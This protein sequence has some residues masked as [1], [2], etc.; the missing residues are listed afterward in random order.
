MRFV[1]VMFDG[2]D[3]VGMTDNTHQ[4]PFIALASA[5]AL[6]HTPAG[7]KV[8]P[9]K[10]L[11][12]Y[13][14]EPIMFPTTVSVMIPLHPEGRTMKAYQAAM[15]EIVI[16]NNGGIHKPRIVTRAH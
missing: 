13:L 3:F 9:F 8:L 7:I 11:D 12:D 1:Q 4:D 15:S 16:P 5:A 2:K 6:I 14:H 10:K